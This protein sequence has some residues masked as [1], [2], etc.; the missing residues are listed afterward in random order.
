M[1]GAGRAGGRRGAGGRPSPA[2]DHRSDA[3]IERLLDLLGRDHV[4]VTVDAAGGDDLA[5][6]GDHLGARPDDDVD[7]GLH[8]RIAGLADAGDAALPKSDI[9]LHD[10]P[11]ID[12]EGIGDDGVDGT[13]GAGALTL[14]HAVADDLAAPE[15][16]LFAVDRVV[17]LDLDEELGVGEAN[18]VA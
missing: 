6:G 2:A 18:T 3:G 7:T 12:D 14:A 10:A 9:G 13:V 8:V 15:L 5:F 11:M 1:P 4:D 17:T 16:H